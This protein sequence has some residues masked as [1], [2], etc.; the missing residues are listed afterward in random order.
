MDQLKQK[1]VRSVLW[2]VIKVAWS[3]LAT[4]L[5][6][7]V[8]TRLLDPH[9][10]GLFALSTLFVDTA[11]VIATAGLADAVAREPNLDEETADTAFWANVVFAITVAI[12]VSLAAYPYASFM[13]EQ[14]LVALVPALSAIMPIT[15]LG[16]I[17]TARLARDFG[18]KAIALRTMLTTLVGGAAGVTCAMS[19]LGV[20]SL[21]IQILLSEVLSLV[22]SWYFYRWVPSLRFS[23]LCLRRLL[24]FSIGMM[25]T[26]VFWVL[27]V[28]VPELFIGRFLGTEAVG[29]YR[30]AWR[31][32][33]FVG[34]AVLAPISSVIL[35]TLSHVQGDAERFARIYGRIVAT[36]GLITYPVLFGFA[37]IGDQ[38]IP[39]VFGE[40]WRDSSG[41]IQIFALMA[42]PFTINYFAGPALAAKGDS[43]AILRVSAMQFVITV[44]FSALAAPYGLYAVA[45]AY[46]V[47]AYLTMFYQISML[48]QRTGISSHKTLTSILP[49]FFAAAIMAVIVYFVGDYYGVTNADGWLFTAALAALGAALYISLALFLA[50]GQ[51]SDA[52]EATG[53]GATKYFSPLRSFLRK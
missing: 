24:G 37:A 2:S 45:I 12:I 13:R 10:F 29:Q 39:L 18:H 20:W 14:T 47:R 36:A 22:M 30:V 28:R 6:F 50:K 25:L 35:I 42:V 3:S 21:V 52:L 48:Q 15:A 9:A 49:A 8:L 51:L 5:V 32:I 31:L 40:Q 19:G 43:S 46:V 27:L 1:T 7:V 26:Q 23:Y 41:L 53:L 16:S 11:R 44:A 17:H 38:L 4:M 33:D 34:Q